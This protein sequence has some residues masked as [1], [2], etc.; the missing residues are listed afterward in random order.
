[1]STLKAIAAAKAAS[2]A[3]SPIADELRCI[4]RLTDYLIEWVWIR[5]DDAK[6][7]HTNDHA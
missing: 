4:A 2:R 6:G 5:N 1:M 3:N 7:E